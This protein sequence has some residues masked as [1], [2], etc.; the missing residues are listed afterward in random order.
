[1]L[2]KARFMAVVPFYVLLLA[3]VSRPLLALDTAL[4]IAAGNLVLGGQTYSHPKLIAT[5]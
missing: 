4:E 2:S 5:Q 1:M 3:V